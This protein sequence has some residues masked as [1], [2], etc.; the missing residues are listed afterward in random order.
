MIRHLHVLTIFL[1]TAILCNTT[2]MHTA[3]AAAPA[4]TPVAQFHRTP[5][6]TTIPAHY[7]V[8]LTGITFPPPE[9][10]RQKLHP[11]EALFV[12]AYSGNLDLLIRAIEAGAN[13]NA[14]DPSTGTSPL[15]FLVERFVAVTEDIATVQHNLLAC[16]EKLLASGAQENKAQRIGMP[17]IQEVL[18]RIPPTESIAAFLALLAKHRAQAAVSSTDTEY[19]ADPYEMHHHR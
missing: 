18:H 5:P 6:P 3:A 19:A 7:L 10:M 9:Q 16:A 15:Y 17:T 11:A 13:V 2:H 12:A 1:I 8:P 14:K 4:P